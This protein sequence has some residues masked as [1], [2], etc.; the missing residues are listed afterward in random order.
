MLKIKILMT[1]CLWSLLGSAFAASHQE[2][3]N[4]QVDPLL[5]F[6]PVAV[7][8][9]ME[10]PCQTVL[11]NIGKVGVHICLERIIIPKP[12]DPTNIMVDRIVEKFDVPRAQA[13]DIV[14][15]A[16]QEAA[17]HNMDPILVLSVIAAE[18]SFNPKAKNPSGAVGLMQAIPRYH[19]STISEL[20]VTS[21][22]LLSVRP[23]IQLG[24][25]ILKIYLAQSDNNLALALQRYNGSV[26]DKRRA[27]SNKVLRYYD[28]LF[29]KKS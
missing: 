21:S 28:W 19:R 10:I 3:P 18:S 29:V 25:E 12:V 14:L 17:L 13:S 23:N 8:S 2:R 11:E 16:H 26:K 6:A 15:T 7:S 22:Q 4:T 27:Y 20:G 1:T 5:A 9:K 24:I